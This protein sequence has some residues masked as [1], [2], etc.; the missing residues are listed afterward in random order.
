MWGLFH[1]PPIH[2][3]PDQAPEILAPSQVVEAGYASCSGLA[4]FLA[5]AC[6]AVGV[7]AR[8]AG[9]RAWVCYWR[10]AWAWQAAGAGRL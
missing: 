1:D 3:K 6:R 4:I 7:P 9:A 10:G 5:S 8:V 2:F